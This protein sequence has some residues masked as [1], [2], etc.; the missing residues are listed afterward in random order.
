MKKTIL[1]FFIVHLYHFTAQGQLIKALPV[2][3][4][5]T[6]AD[7]FIGLDSMDHSYYIKDNVFYKKNQTAIWQYKNVSWGQITKVDLQNPLKLVLFYENFNAVV[8]LDN[9]L[10]EIQK[11]NLSNNQDP[12][13]AN[14]IGLATQNQ[15]WVYNS[16]NQQIGLYNYLKNEYK[17]ISTSFP[18]SILYY[19]STLTTFYWIDKKNQW[20]SCDRFGKITAIATT[21]AFDQIE[22][23]SDNQYLYSKNSIISIEDIAKKEKYEI[24]ILEKSFK[25]F[26]YKDQI[27]SIFTSEGIT[28]YKIIIP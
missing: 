14:A 20:Y 7:V 8:I 19:Q 12:I 21:T 13:I 9:Q 25:Y 11:I 23:I 10:N 17:S 26:T 16:F 18:E 3:S 4:Q 5:K 22:I 15:L 28:N 27:L 24:E 1:L 6:D 2:S